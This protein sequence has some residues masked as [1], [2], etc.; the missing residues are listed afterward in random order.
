MTSSAAYELVPVPRLAVRFPLELPLPDGFVAE[1]PAT[2]PDVEGSLELVGGRL[3]YMP[4]CADR[5][6]YTTADVVLVLGVW[7]RSHTEFLVAGNDAGML[8]GGDSRGADAAVW[9]HDAVGSHRGR[10]QRVAPVLAVEV[11]G[12]LEEETELRAKARWYLDHGVEVVW[13]LRPVDRTAT[14]VT[15]SAAIDLSGEAEIPAHPSLP[16]LCAP[17]AELFAQVSATAP[18]TA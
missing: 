3:L 10:F 1:E 2:W 14:V 12:E 18:E 13:L 6:Q 16:G 17:L 7:R 11:M 8:L 9:R 5:Q 15:A 4:P